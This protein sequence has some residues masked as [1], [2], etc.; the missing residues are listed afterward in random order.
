MDT[1]V[2][3]TALLLPLHIVLTAECCEAPVTGLDDFLAAG[4]LELGTTQSLGCLQQ[5]PSLS[6]MKVLLTR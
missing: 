3:N 2:D 5:P 6:N 1:T 4:E